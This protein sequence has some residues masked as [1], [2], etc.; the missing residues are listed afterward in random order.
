MD[1]RTIIGLILAF[2][3]IVLIQRELVFKRRLQ[4]QELKAKKDLHDEDL[5]FRKAVEDETR[6]GREVNAKWMQDETARLG[7]LAEDIA[8][9]ITRQLV[10]DTSWATSALKKARLGHP[11]QTI[12]TDRL[13]HFS[14]E[15]E[16]L[17]HNFVPLLLMR[18]RQL[19]E[20]GHE[21]YLIIDAGTTMY[22]LFSRLGSAA[23]KCWRNRELWVDSITIVTNNLP[24]VQSLMDTGRV[25]PTNRYSELAIKCELLPGAPLPVYSSVTGE[26]TT[27]TLNAMRTRHSKSAVFVGVVS[28]NWV[29][30]SRSHSAPI[31]LSR[32]QGHQKFK[33]AVVTEADEVYVLAPLG[34][35]FVDVGLE[36]LNSAL[37]FD[38]KH[39]DTE[40][41]PYSEVFLTE[42]EAKKVRLVSTSRL[43]GRVLSHL[44]QKLQT[45]LKASEGDCY[46]WTADGM[47]PHWLFEYDR[48][49]Q[50]RHEELA[51]EF[52][53]AYT[54]TPDFMEK[55]FFVPRN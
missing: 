39:S 32:G 47:I 10:E 11:S 13:N 2:A 53:H 37:G 23:V 31:P 7:P 19:A 29:R 42:D 28:G 1:A 8:S 5:A 30:V 17:A 26:L 20:E 3:T 34:K 46:Q 25:D 51:V 50:S 55:Y 18:C 54:R 16:H 15:K 36:E 44:S 4:E 38:R 49:P 48:L 14:D 22:P 27:D 21:V 35:I 33:E 9:I 12:F 41:Q 45:L 6:R 40:R 52:P 43:D 24:G